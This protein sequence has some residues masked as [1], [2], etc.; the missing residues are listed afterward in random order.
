[1][2]YL[3]WPLFNLFLAP[4][5]FA[6]T[7]T[8]MYESEMAFLNRP[9]NRRLF[10]EL[11]KNQ[12][13]QIRIEKLSEL[14]SNFLAHT[15]DHRE[16]DND[17][18]E[19][20]EEARPTWWKVGLFA[21]GMAPVSFLVSSSFN[22]FAE[23][24]AAQSIG[25]DLAGDLAEHL[26]PSHNISEDVFSISNNRSLDN[27]AENEAAALASAPLLMDTA[28]LTSYATLVATDRLPDNAYAQMGLFILVAGHWVDLSAQ[29]LISEYDNATEVLENYVAN[30]T[31]LDAV[32]SRAI[33]RGSQGLILAGGAIS[34]AYGLRKMF[35]Q[36][37]LAGE[38]QEERERR[39]RRFDL[40]ERFNLDLSPEFTDNYRG[41]SITGQF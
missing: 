8:D 38:E 16:E 14:P 2:K 27:L 22:D 39:H 23:Y 5:I 12:D 11:L 29:T 10:S 6:Q 31:G 28:V 1:M 17:L 4:L 9:A 33:I 36:V 19:Q 13:I 35:I 34:M 21:Y 25:V 32:S 24:V 41:I 40:F 37:G 3:I 30:S 7:T 26:G 15:E 20:I 18:I